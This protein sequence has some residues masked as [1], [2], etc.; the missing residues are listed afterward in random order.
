[1]PRKSSVDLASVSTEKA[2]WCWARS[3]TMTEYLSDNQVLE[4]SDFWVILLKMNL[5]KMWFSIDS[6]NFLGDVNHGKDKVDKL[7]H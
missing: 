7:D 2:S 1:M 3:L 6:V 4:L 5:R